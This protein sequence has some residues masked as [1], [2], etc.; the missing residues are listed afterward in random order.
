MPDLKFG[1]MVEDDEGG[2]Y[3]VVVPYTGLRLEGDQQGP[4]H[5]IADINT[6]FSEAGEGSVTWSIDEDLVPL[7]AS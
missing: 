7:D 6:P 4:A 3:M 2:V 1:E 5:W